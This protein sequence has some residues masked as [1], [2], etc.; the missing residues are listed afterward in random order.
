MC[1]LKFNPNPP[2]P[3]NER[4]MRKYIDYTRIMLLPRKRKSSDSQKFRGNS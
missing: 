4:I 1:V 3:K 2:K